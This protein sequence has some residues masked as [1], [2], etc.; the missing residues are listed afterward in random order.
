MAKLYPHASVVGV[1]L[2]P[3]PVD[4]STLPSNCRFEVDDVNL[5]LQHFHGAYDVVHARLISSGLK[6]YR[7]MMEEAEKCLKPGGVVIFID[8]D[9]QFC[10]E[11]QVSRQPMAESNENGSWLV[12]CSHGENYTSSKAFYLSNYT[13][14]EMRNGAPLM[15]S[16]ILGMEAALDEGVWGHELID[17]ETYVLSIKGVVCILTPHHSAQ[18]ASM[19]LPIGPWPRGIIILCA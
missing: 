14:I 1:D 6:S 9:A 2:A 7:K 8:Y 3:V 13:G 5:G 16:D 4:R 10:A 18:A 11:D 17:P 15:G 12:R 19:F